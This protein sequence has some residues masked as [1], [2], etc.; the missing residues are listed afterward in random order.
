M[1]PN[2]WAFLTGVRGYALRGESTLPTEGGKP[3]SSI[4]SNDKPSDPYYG[5]KPS[6][7]YSNYGNKPTDN[8]SDYGN[9]PTDNY[10]NYNNKPSDNYSNYGNKPSDT[11]Y[12]NKPSES[13]FSGFDYQED[14]SYYKPQTSHYENDYMDYFYG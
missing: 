13:Y 2:A 4:E 12:G 3:Q 8:Y 7:D 9:K 6:G 14:E 11:Y 10:S 5:N 1:T